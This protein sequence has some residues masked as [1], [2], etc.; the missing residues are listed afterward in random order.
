[1]FKLLL[2][3]AAVWLIVLLLRQYRRSVDAPR[4][5]SPPQEDMVRCSKCGL[6]LPRSSS[7][8]KHGAYYCCEQHSDRA[9]Q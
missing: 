9:R 7:I 3:A 5:A 2:L 6:Y 8:L 1:M 4:G